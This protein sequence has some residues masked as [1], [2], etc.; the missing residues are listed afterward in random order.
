M[1]VK[2]W[3]GSQ[4]LQGQQQ[5]QGL[6]RERGPGLPGSA[7]AALCGS[8]LPGAGRWETVPP[9]PLPRL[10]PQEQREAGVSCAF[11]TAGFGCK[12]KLCCEELPKGNRTGVWVQASLMLGGRLSH[13]KCKAWA[14]VVL[15]KSY[16]S[17]ENAFSSF[18]S[19]S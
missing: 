1:P 8:C 14:D 3:L 16:D 15:T 11:F 19:R 17:V 18:F 6:G 10:G 4:V 5:Q 9:I 2:R 13:C 12:V 7:P